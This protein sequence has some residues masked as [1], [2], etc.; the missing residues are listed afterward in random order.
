MYPF[1]EVMDYAALAKRLPWTS[2]VV[3]LHCDGNGLLAVEKPVGAL[4]HPNRRGEEGK[5]LLAAPYDEKRQVYEVEGAVAPVHLL[6]RL[7]SATSGVVLLALD[8]KVAAAALEAF[9][10]KQVRKVYEALVFGLP[11][12]GP[13]R[14]VD[15]ISVKHA[16]GGVRA[17][18]GG[19][20][21][22]ETTLLKAQALPGSPF[23]ARL[24]LMPLTGRTHQLRIQ[25]SLR[26][27]PIVGDRTY[28][29]FAKNK[30]VAKARGLKRLCL[31]CVETRLVYRIGGASVEFAARSEC[32]F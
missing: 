1:P 4:S 32:P 29:D 9:E 20:L 13:A 26:G 27:S 21:T 8:T 31:H 11:R 16:E 12:P 28:G 14:W 6:N 19:S 3:V 25:T 17:S 2:G 30:A 22:A 5:A 7:D 15:R 10:K 18:S 24:S 23:M